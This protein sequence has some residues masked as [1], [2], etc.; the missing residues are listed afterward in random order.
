MN[1]NQTS[2][3]F[4]YYHLFGTSARPLGS[5]SRMRAHACTKSKLDQP[6]QQESTRASNPPRVKFNQSIQISKSP[7]EAG[8]WRNQEPI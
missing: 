3:P 5:A 8:R 7:T 4:I 1:R 2:T 6:V